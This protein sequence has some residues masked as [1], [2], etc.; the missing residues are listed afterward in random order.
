MICHQLDISFDYRRIIEVTII[1][2]SETIENL[3]AGT[4]YVNNDSNVYY[5]KSDPF[6]DIDI[7]HSD[8]KDIR[9]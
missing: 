3:S 4:L 2:E 6:R 9:I 7:N 8:G 1:D 5:A